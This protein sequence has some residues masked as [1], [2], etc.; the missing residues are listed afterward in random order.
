MLS[1]KVSF[2]LCD[3]FAFGLFLTVLKVVKLDG[4][5]NQFIPAVAVLLDKNWFLILLYGFSHVGIRV[6]Q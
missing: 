5:R 1:G 3:F 6:I 4:A 2:Y